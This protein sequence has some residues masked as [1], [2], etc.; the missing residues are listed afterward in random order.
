MNF[1]SASKRI[2]KFSRS[3][4]ANSQGFFVQVKN[5]TF[6]TIGG[7]QPFPWKPHARRKVFELASEESSG[8]VMHERER[9]EGACFRKRGGKKRGMAGRK[10]KREGR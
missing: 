1:G 10:K 7:S 5:L 6:L 2:Y 4:K 8:C 9:E 3:L